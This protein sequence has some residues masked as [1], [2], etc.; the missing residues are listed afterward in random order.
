MLAVYAFQTKFPRLTSQMLYGNLTDT[1]R[2]TFNA[3]NNVLQ[4]QSFGQF[5]KE[6]ILSYSY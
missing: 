3:M 6:A 5:A 4:Y 2:N 1:V